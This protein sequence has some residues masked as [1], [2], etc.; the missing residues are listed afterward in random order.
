MTIT[1]LPGRNGVS[2]ASRSSR[3]KA[4]RTSVLQFAEKVSQ[5]CWC[6]GRISGL[7]QATM[8]SLFG[9]WRSSNVPGTDGSAASATST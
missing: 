1:R 9:W 7:A 8:S 2:K 3:W 5:V 4:M 6:S